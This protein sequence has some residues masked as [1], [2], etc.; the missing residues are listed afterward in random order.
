MK[1]MDVAVRV[2]KTSLFWCGMMLLMPAMLLLVPK[3]GYFHTY[4]HT[5]IH[6]P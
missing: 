2:G 3:I 5:Y 4:V 1:E 6:R